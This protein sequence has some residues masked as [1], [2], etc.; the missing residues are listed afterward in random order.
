MLEIE[1]VRYG[2]LT[3]YDLYF[4]EAFA[5]IAREKVDVFIVCSLQ[6][7]DTHDAL[8]IMCRF[9]AYQTNAYVLRSSVS[10]EENATVCGASMIVSPTGKILCNMLGRYGMEIAEFDP[11]DKYYKRAGFGGQLAPHYEYLEYGRK[12]WQYRIGGPSIVTF[13]RWMKYPRV[14]AHRP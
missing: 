8:E 2:F 1:G 3:C 4:Y 14:C 12:P 11:H 10:F 7:T 5:R 9:L 13:D 6:R